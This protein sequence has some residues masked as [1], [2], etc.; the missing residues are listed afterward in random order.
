MPTYS[1]SRQS[2]LLDASAFRAV[3]K[4]GRRVKRRPFQLIARPNQARRPRL[5]IAVS[6]RNVRRASARNLIKRLTRESFRLH[7]GTLPD[8]DVVVLVGPAA[9]DYGRRRYSADLAGAWASLAQRAGGN[10]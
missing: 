6:K 2:R 9:A 4:E 5:G 8:V 1:F 10:R 7:Q 3:F